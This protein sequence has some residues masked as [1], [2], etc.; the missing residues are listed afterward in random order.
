MKSLLTILATILVAV[1]INAQTCLG[2]LNNSYTV[3]ITDVLIFVGEYGSECVDCPADISSDGMVNVADLLV[4]ASAFGTSCIQA[5]CDMIVEEVQI[6]L[7]LNTPASGVVQT[8]PQNGTEQVP[9]LY[10]DIS[11]EGVGELMSLYV[12]LST[13]INS[14]YDMIDDITIYCDGE[15]VAQVT[16]VSEYMIVEFM[17]PVEF[18][19]EAKNFQL[20]VNLEQSEGNYDCYDWFEVAVLPAEVISCNGEEVEPELISGEAY[21][22]RLYVCSGGIVLNL[23]SSSHSIIYDGFYTSSVHYEIVVDVEAIGSDM[24]VSSNVNYGTYTHVMST[25]IGNG[26]SMMVAFLDS[27]ADLNQ[28]E[29]SYIVDEGDVEELN[30]NSTLIPV[31]SGFYQI[32]LTQFE[33][34]L[35]DGTIVSY[36]EELLAQMVS[37]ILFLDP[38]TGEIVFGQ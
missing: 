10:F 38:G 5:S 26:S 33:L 20:K 2:D 6:E 9:A 37:E 19:G 35:P 16:S 31:E 22:N 25:S 34:K 13:S 11:V 4:V 36:P 8:N 21:G 3:D 28:T 32:A 17:E 15:I 24:L 1:S 12:V 29:D 7:S 30:F 27:T 23:V 14:V 18:E